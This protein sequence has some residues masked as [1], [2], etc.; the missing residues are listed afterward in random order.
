MAKRYPYDTSIDALLSPAKGAV[1]FEQW[2]PEDF[3]NECLLCAE[4]SRLAYSSQVVIKDALSRTPFSHVE[5]IGGDDVVSRIETGGTQAFIASSATL[6]V[7]VLSF[8]GTQSDSPEDVITDLLILP[9]P[10]DANGCRV[11]GGFARRAR[12]IAEQ[13]DRALV[14]QEG[15]LLIT[16]HSLGAALATLAAIDGHADKLITFGSPRVGD[17]R[18]GKL[19]TG[20]EIHR[21]VDCCDV[22]ARVPP[23]RFDAAHL[24]TLFRELTVLDSPAGLHPGW[25]QLG[26]KALET[27]LG[28]VATLLSGAFEFVN[29]N[30]E[31]S[32]VF[33][34]V[35]V[36]A[37]GKIS[38]PASDDDVPRDQAMARTCYPHRFRVEQLPGLLTELTELARV[39]PQD[40]PRSL[41][42]CLVRLLRIGQVP[43]RDLADHAP[44][45][46]LSAI[47]G[48]TAE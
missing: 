16:G 15:A 30:I 10:P 9:G 36:H 37:D 12:Q 5:F 26:Q 24:L 2:T 48:R 46:Y 18:I 29:P 11:H 3:K 41:A 4:M 21:F 47:T 22:V 20:V 19:L 28:V 38:T 35:Y 43:S 34:L 14:G 44:I 45:N 23:E 42:Q 31:F 6:G 8:R 7:K 13:T 25:A 40:L 32:H 1:F 17:S 33:G 39:P 27:G